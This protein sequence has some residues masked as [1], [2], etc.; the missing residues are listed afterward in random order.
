MIEAG[1]R[2]VFRCLVNSTLGL[3]TI[4]WLA[5]ISI[6][7]AYA[8]APTG[9]VRGVAKL[10][11]DSTSIPFALV[12]L[13]PIDTNRPPRDGITNAQGRFQFAAVPVGAYRLQLMRIGYR[14][15]LTPVIE[16]QAGVTT[17]QDIRGSMIGLP[18][19]AVVT[20]ADGACLT[21]D[22]LAANTYLSA[23]WE[24]IRKGV[25][26]RR[27][28]DLRYRYVWEATDSSQTATPSHPVTRRDTVYTFKNDPNLVIA[29][30]T[31][32]REQR[33][34]KGYGSGDAFYWLDEREL[35]DAE[36]LQMNCISPS[37][38]DTARLLGVSFRQMSA[39]RRGFGLSGTIW[40]DASTRIIRRIDAQYLNGDRPSGNVTTEYDDVAVGGTTLRLPMSAVYSL[41][42]SQ[43]PPGTTSS[44][45]MRFRYR[46]FEEIPPK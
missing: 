45:T 2:A 28:F 36:F 12:R 9:A 18:L 34:A 46:G 29:R 33:T 27:A 25:E 24:D 32:L 39:R 40:V 21:A 19:P 14:P 11:E 6:P 43:S 20:Y 26:I 16:V 4:I 17:D 31:R 3:I 5:A 42:L 30:A 15:A 1:R 22:R 7:S 41:Q 37:R 38:D 8:Q 13:V 44:G 23:L 35:L 10:S